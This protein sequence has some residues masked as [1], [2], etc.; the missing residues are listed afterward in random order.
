M[1]SSSD[2]CS[3]SR[4]WPQKWNFLKGF[5]PGKGHAK[6]QQMWWSLQGEWNWL[7]TIC[8]ESI[9][10]YF[11]QIFSVISLQPENQPSYPSSSL[12]RLTGAVF[13]PVQ[14]IPEHQGCS[15]ADGE[16]E[17]GRP[18]DLTLDGPV[19]RMSP[20]LQAAVIASSLSSCTACLQ[21]LDCY[22]VGNVCLHVHT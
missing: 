2:S 21:V 16:A 6:I 10:T 7:S 5:L 22:L 15:T 17:M 4:A 19:G 11:P 14:H 13:A 9:L 1:F 18:K 3:G 12:R 20:S 8:M